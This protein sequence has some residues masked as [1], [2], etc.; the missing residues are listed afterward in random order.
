[1]T[2]YRPDRVIRTGVIEPFDFSYGFDPV[3]NAFRVA[4]PVTGYS[5]TGSRGRTALMITKATGADVTAAGAASVK[6]ARTMHAV[7]GKAAVA[8]AITKAAG[9]GVAVPSSAAA[10]TSYDEAGNLIVD[11]NQPRGIQRVQPALSRGGRYCTPGA[12]VMRMNPI[13]RR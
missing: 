12:Q 7:P 3:Q 2:R 5:P 6:P 1:M 11:S 9:L 8:T 10:Y 13:T 4:R